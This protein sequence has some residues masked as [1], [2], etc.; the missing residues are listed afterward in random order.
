MIQKYHGASEHIP[1]SESPKPVPYPLRDVVNRNNMTSPCCGS[2]NQDINR[3]VPY[4][5]IYP[6][7]SWGQY[8]A[9]QPITYIV[10]PV[11]RG[12]GAFR[13]IAPNADI[14]NMGG[15]ILTYLNTLTSNWKETGVRLVSSIDVK[16]IFASVAV[17]ATFK[18]DAANEN[19]TVRPLPFDA[20]EFVCFFPII[21]HDKFLPIQLYRYIKKDLSYIS[22]VSVILQWT[23]H[24]H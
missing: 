2:L 3:C 15:T 5:V 16:R 19:R 21:W 20:V 13:V 7:S 6:N 17:F 24:D 14:K 11:T 23:E 10:A 22:V 18:V 4:S 8:S 9:Q 1:R 12:W